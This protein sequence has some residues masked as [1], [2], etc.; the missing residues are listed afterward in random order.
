MKS[1]TTI[2]PPPSNTPETKG[3]YS[4][5][6][7]RENAN[8]GTSYCAQGG[9]TAK[10]DLYMAA[11]NG[12][13]EAVGG[14]YSML[15]TGVEC[16]GEIPQGI[17]VVSSDTADIRE[18]AV[19]NIKR[20]L[21]TYPSPISTD[22]EDEIPTGMLPPDAIPTGILPEEY[23][24]NFRSAYPEGEFPNKL[25]ESDIEAEKGPQDSEWIYVLR[26]SEYMLRDTIIP[27]AGEH[28][29]PEDA[30]PELTENDFET[31]LPPAPTDNDT[32][33]S[34]SNLIYN[35]VSEAINKIIEESEIL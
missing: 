7:E 27:P 26:P 25:D 4:I 28:D 34:Y 21:A 11:S 18:T 20:T 32:L 13:L 8:N 5:I 6:A 22:S 24:I 1:R 9:Q 3:R 19:N 10:E 33:G 2:L 12:T 17:I 23:V 15:N 29:I 16:V 14:Q 35:E 30:L 31:M